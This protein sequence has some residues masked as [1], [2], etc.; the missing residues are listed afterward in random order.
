MRAREIISEDFWDKQAE[1]NRLYNPEAAS[2]ADQ[3]AQH[4]PEQTEVVTAYK[5]S[6]PRFTNRVRR[7][8]TASAGWRG[9]VSVQARS[10]H[11]TD[12]KRDHLFSQ[13]AQSPDRS[14]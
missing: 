8:H 6:E 5:S 2:Y 14:E 11:I 10:G 1:L 13:T 9:Q 12:D 7:G 3:Q 4:T